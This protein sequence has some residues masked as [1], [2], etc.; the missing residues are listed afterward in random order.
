MNCREW[1]ELLEAKRMAEFGLELN[2][3]LL[4]AAELQRAERV[5]RELQDRVAY[6]M[7]HEKEI[8]A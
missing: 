5:V 3:K 8:E 1:V 7:E 2:R 6:W 4:G